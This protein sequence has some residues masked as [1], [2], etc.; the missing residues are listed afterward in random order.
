VVNT[1]RNLLGRFAL[2]NFSGDLSSISCRTI[3]S[4]LNRKAI[5]QHSSFCGALL[6]AKNLTLDL[7][8]KAPDIIGNSFKIN[9]ENYIRT[10]WRTNGRKNKRTVLTD[11]S[12]ATLSLT[13]LAI[14]I[15]PPKCDGCL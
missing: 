2:P 12:T 9:L 8:R 10:D 6:N 14:S 13:G 5:R 7:N 4:I 3:S 15:R 11:V 1:G